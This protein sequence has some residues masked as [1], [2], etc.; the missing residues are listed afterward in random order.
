MLGTVATSAIGVSSFARSVAW[1]G[2]IA[3]L[4]AFDTEARK[5]V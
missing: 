3:M 5:I 1:P 4:V 2:E